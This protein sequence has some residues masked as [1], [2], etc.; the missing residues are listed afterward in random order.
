MPRTQDFEVL[1]KFENEHYFPPDKTWPEYEFQY[2]STCRWALSQIREYM[3]QKANEHKSMT[4]ILEELYWI[5][6][7]GIAECCE[8]YDE[9]TEIK[10]WRYPP[11]DL[12]FS[13]GRA[14][15]EEV[16]GLFL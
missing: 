6:D 4:D 16:A 12:V 13:V 1:D 9:K 5:F 2:Q 11:P 10:A 8:M 15:V 3:A 14:M 7:T